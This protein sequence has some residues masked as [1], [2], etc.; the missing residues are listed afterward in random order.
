MTKKFLSYAIPSALAMFIS[1]L[2]TVIDG[3]FVGQGVGDLAL[4]AVNVVIPL[5]IMLFGMAT[6]FAVGGGA[7]IS[8]NFGSKDVE[9]A[10]LMFHQVFKFL[11]IISFII[12]ITC[13]IF[14][15]PIVKGLGA[16]PDLYD[17]A[18]TYL[19]FYSL[20]CIPNIIGIALN[21]FIRNDGNP[22]LAMIATLS[23]AITNIVLDYL[24]IFP[25]Q[26]GLFGAAMATGLGQVVTVSIILIHFIRRQGRLRFGNV[27]L[28]FNII[29]E[30]SSI[31][32]PSF[33]A[34]AA[35]SIIIYLTNIALV[36][37]VGEI[38]ITTYSIINYL[39]TPI[40]LLLL[41]LAFGAQPLISYHFGA[42]EQ[43]PMMKYYRLSNKTNYL[44]NFLFIAICFFFGRPIIS[45]FTQDPTI[46]D[47]AYVGLNI[48]NAAFIII[49]LN[50]N[51]TIYYQAI[52]TPKYSNFLCACRSVIFLP[53]VLFILT[54]LFGLH[55]IWA[56]LM[57]SE[58]LTL[59]AF[60]IFTNIHHIT[61]QAIQ[62][63]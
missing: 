54:N 13:V 28:N 6:M 47:M 56:A 3:I 20:F 43:E 46:I 11:L 27:K 52:E 31:G 8:K 21:S 37:T 34:E 60:L 48:V 30:F 22:K 44:I 4:A 25:L 32:F 2:Y 26:L 18:K 19:R 41:G 40:Y 53:I 33:F 9:T 36:K 16:T 24:F 63:S 58:L 49:G 55:G 29:K 7:L 62:L 35:F 12:S 17:L 42:K 59:L 61:K 51:T 23:G 10:N 1:S 50:L 57:V 5:T 39:T 45:I 15:G 38:G 14:A